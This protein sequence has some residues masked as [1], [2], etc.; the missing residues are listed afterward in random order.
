[1]VNEVSRRQIEARGLKLIWKNPKTSPDH[2]SIG[3]KMEK[4][5]R[6]YGKNYANRKSTNSDHI[7]DGDK[8]WII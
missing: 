7:P 4:Y 3:H 5:C 2:G 8:R 1:M 6:G